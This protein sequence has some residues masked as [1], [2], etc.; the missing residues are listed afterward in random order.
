MAGKRPGLRVVCVKQ[1]QNTER[2]V[3]WATWL[4]FEFSGHLFHLQPPTFCGFQASESPNETPRP[5]YRTSGHLVEPE[6]CALS[7]PF[8]AIFLLFHGH[9]AEVEG[10]KG[11]FAVRK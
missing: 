11:L 3:S 6:G 10:K 2:V 9:I 7:G 8:L 5:P 1:P 4:K